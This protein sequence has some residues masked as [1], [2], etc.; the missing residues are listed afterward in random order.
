MIKQESLTI[1]FWR[2]I[3]TQNPWK[4]FLLKLV[5]NV[6]YYFASPCEDMGMKAVGWKSRRI[7]N[8]LKLKTQTC[9]KE[10][11]SKIVFFLAIIDQAIISVKRCCDQNRHTRNILCFHEADKTFTQATLIRRRRLM[12]FGAACGSKKQWN[13]FVSQN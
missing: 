4:H 8:I 9:L 12:I 11:H 6:N 13:M 10:K 1:A 5:R 2:F 3:F 7:W